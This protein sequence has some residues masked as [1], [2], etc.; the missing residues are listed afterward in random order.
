MSTDSD[1]TPRALVDGH[2]R[3]V[4]YLRVSVTDR[5][6]L[7]C[8]YCMPERMTFL[9]KKH[10]LTLEELAQVAELF[11][12][13]GVRKIRLTGGEPLMRKNVMWLID[14]LGGW[15]GRGLDELTLTTNATQLERYAQDLWQAGVRRLNISLDSLDP[16]RYRDITRWGDLAPVLR[17]LQA[18]KD[19]GMKIKLNCVALK[20]LNEDEFD[21]LIEWCAKEGFDLVFIEVMPM[22]E[23]TNEKRIAQYL[24]LSDL[25]QEIDRRHGLTA[26]PDRT[27]G[28]ARYHRVE[29]YGSRIGFIS[30]LS[31]RFCESCNRVRLTCTGMLYSC[32]GQSGN[33]DLRA[34]LREPEQPLEKTRAAIFDCLAHKPKGHDFLIERQNV[35]HTDRYMNTTGG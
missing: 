1:K 12:G 35:Q 18:A 2:G 7:R 24:S 10:L 22:G 25:Q 27:G 30:P 20:N 15:V 14:H 21:F 23:M 5:C 29:R 4:D 8:H 6:D 32:L 19:V 28:P 31:N 34:T 13:H 16:Q 26:L 9:P 3:T 17:G 11:I 33:R